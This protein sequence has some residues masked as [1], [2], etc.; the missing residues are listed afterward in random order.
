[1]VVIVITTSPQAGM[2]LNVDRAGELSIVRSSLFSGFG[3]ISFAFVSQT[4]TFLLYR[5]LGVKDRNF[6]MWYW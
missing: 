2:A 6:E 5:S 4:S 3:A 1:M